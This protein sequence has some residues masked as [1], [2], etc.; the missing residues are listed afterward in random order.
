MINDTLEKRL[1]E[2]E[3]LPTLPL[4]LRQLQKVIQNERTS[5]AQIAAVVAKDQ[6][7]ASKAI[8]LVNS[9]WYGRTTRI[10]SIQQV[11]VTL[12]LSTLNTLMLGLTVIKLFD[13]SRTHGF[14]ARSFWEHSFGTA[15]LAKK[16]ALQGGKGCDAEECFVAGLLHDMGR[17]VMEQHLHEEYVAA[18]QLMQNNKQT[19]LS[20]EEAIFGFSHTD[21]GAWLGK[22]WNIP[23]KLILAMELHHSLLFPPDLTHQ[24]KEVVK[25]VSAAN[26]LCLEGNIGTSGEL[27]NSPGTVHPHNGFSTE[28]CIRLVGETQKEVT[29]TL[30]EWN[31]L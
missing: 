31:T 8:R 2:I 16:L 30:R 23:R 10:T 14:N 4:V 19:L 1:E 20:A 12:G 28:T 22:K 27:S 3:G 7:L 15:L 5:M 13:N 18:L 24:E 26:K 11:L 21:T 25:I 29:A 17:L 6:A 9:A